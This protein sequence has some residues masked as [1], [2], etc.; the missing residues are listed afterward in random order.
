[1]RATPKVFS[2]FVLVCSVFDW[3]LFYVIQRL[4][5]FVFPRLSLHLHIKY[6]NCLT[7]AV[8][9]YGMAA[10]LHDN[11][12]PNNITGQLYTVCFFIVDL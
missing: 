6:L 8:C 11:P 10:V 9:P 12:C 1:M 2:S 5:T 7:N 3:V 4:E